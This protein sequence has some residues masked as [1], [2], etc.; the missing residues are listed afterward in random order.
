MVRKR[1]GSARARS[2][3]MGLAHLLARQREHRLGPFQARQQGPA[4]A[5]PPPAPAPCDLWSWISAAS[6]HHAACQRR[7]ACGT[8]S[9]IRARDPGGG[10]HVV[11]H[12][13]VVD[14]HLWR[15]AC[16]RRAPAG[17]VAQRGEQPRPT[18]T[19]ASAPWSCRWSS[20][21][22]PSSAAVG[23][24]ARAGET[25]A[26]STAASASST[27]RKSAKSASVCSVQQHRG[28]ARGGVGVTA[29]AC[30]GEQLAQRVAHA[31]RAGEHLGQAVLDRRIRSPHGLPIL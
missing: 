2:S 9:C 3:T 26:A 30:A 29:P 6:R 13:V 14:Q 8:T 10:R 5:R 17:A 25:G 24:P 15:A 27:P 21:G 16:A 23:A 28:R 12:V 19:S 11:A 20:E 22:R 31:G 18:G 4:G 7:A 1:L